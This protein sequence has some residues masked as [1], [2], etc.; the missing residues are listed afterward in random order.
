VR[1]D[2]LT[3]L[4]LCPAEDQVFI[5]VFPNANAFDGVSF[6]RGVVFVYHCIIVN[7]N[8]FP[9]AVHPLWETA[10]SEGRFRGPRIFGSWGQREGLE[11]VRRIDQ[12]GRTGGIATQSHLDVAGS[13]LVVIQLQ[14]NVPEC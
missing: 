2:T 6:K 5:V 4:P 7:T 14:K 8:V 10:S 11:A 9:I 12:V 13:I 3:F 1:I